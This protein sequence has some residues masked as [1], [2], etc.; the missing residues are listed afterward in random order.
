M[1][2]SMMELFRKQTCTRLTKGEDNTDD[3]AMIAIPQAQNA[4]RP[5]PW[6][7]RTFTNPP[8]W[9]MRAHVDGSLQ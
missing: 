8:E 2:L 4:P 7:V 1:T 5:L 3:V 6:P 9:R